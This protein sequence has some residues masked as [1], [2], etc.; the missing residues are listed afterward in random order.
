[1]EMFVHSQIKL[2]CVNFYSLISYKV[3]NKCFCA[4]ISVFSLDIDIDTDI[5][6]T[7]L[8]TFTHL[9][10]ILYLIECIIMTCCCT[11][12]ELMLLME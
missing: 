10:P 6:I 1:M 4:L 8:C 2:T 9:C 12:V 5:G 3:L 11:R 7:V